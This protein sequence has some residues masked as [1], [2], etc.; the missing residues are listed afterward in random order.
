MI[1][2]ADRNVFLPEAAWKL[3]RRLRRKNSRSSAASVQPEDAQNLRWI[4]RERGSEERS[5][6]GRRIQCNHENGMDSA[7]AW[8]RVR[9]H[10]P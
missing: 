3:M 1:A 5:R 7:S 6:M 8:E 2:P 10:E 4:E 9:E